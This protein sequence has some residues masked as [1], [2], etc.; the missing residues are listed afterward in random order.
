MLKVLTSKL[1]LL[2]YVVL[3]IIWGFG[4]EDDVSGFFTFCLHA[5]LFLFMP[6]DVAD[7]QIS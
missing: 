7:K 2:C 1:V 5:L 4:G 6:L 3:R